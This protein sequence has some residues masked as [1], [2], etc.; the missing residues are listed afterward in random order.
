M[1]R[2]RETWCQLLEFQNI[3]ARDKSVSRHHDTKTNEDKGF[4]VET[5]TEE[6]NAEDCIPYAQ[7]SELSHL[8]I[9]QAATKAK[10]VA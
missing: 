6:L 3:K 7:Q 8:R 2:N 9:E 10:L 5:A 4:V 1:T